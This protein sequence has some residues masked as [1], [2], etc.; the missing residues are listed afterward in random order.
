MKSLLLQCPPTPEKSEHAIRSM[1]KKYEQSSMLKVWSWHL[2][3]LS[4]KELYSTIWHWIDVVNER[5]LDNFREMDRSRVEGLLIIMRNY[6][7]VGIGQSVGLMNNHGTSECIQQELVLWIMKFFFKIIE[8]DTG[9]AHFT[10][11]GRNLFQFYTS[12]FEFWSIYL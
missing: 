2:V 12:S 5:I 11:K 3:E 10:S 1:S 7:L 9:K 6:T 8:V 4:K